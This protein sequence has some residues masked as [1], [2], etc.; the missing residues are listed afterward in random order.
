MKR[1]LM[2]AAV[3]AV[4]L[5]AFSALASS[6]ALAFTLGTEECKGGVAAELA[7]LCWAESETG[8]LLELTGTETETVSSGAVTLLILTEPTQTIDCNKSKGSGTVTQTEVLTVGAQTLPTTIEGTITYEECTLLEPPPG[9]TIK[10]SETTKEILGTLDS[11][12][13]VKLKPKTGEVFIEIEYKGATC[14]LKGKHSV[15]GTQDAEIVE[16]TKEKLTITATAVA[17]VG[18]GLTFL[19]SPADLTQ[20]LTL[21]FTGVDKEDWFDIVPPGTA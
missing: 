4:T 17:V 5:V 13:I 3:A 14:A 15:T 18:T 6:S 9:C 8:V 11:G 1:Y 19:S 7:R 12:T 16:P 10:T 20:T 2:V 21:T